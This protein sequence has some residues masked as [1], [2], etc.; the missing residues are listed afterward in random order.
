MSKKIVPLKDLLSETGLTE[1]DVWFRCPVCKD[2]PEEENRIVRHSI[3]VPFK[4]YNN[5]PYW[6]RTG[7]SIENLSVTPSIK[8]LKGC[9]FHGFITNGNIEYWVD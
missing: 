6:S 3:Y 2:K 8:V 9:G 7:D 4:S 1:E 5:K